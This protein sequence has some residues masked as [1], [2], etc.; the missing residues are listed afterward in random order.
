MALEGDM[1]ST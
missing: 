1:Y